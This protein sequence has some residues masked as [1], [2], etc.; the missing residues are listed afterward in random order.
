MGH[1]SIAFFPNGIDEVGAFGVIGR[2]VLR[3]APHIDSHV[4]ITWQSNRLQLSCWQLECVFIDFMLC[5]IL[6]RPCS[7]VVGISLRLFHSGGSVAVQQV[8]RRVVAAHRRD[9]VQ[10]PST[11]S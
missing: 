9:G 4:Q 5:A 2:V 1:Y 3:S 8:H 10:H 6:R 7:D 11:A